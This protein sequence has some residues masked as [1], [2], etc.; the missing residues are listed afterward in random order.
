MAYNIPVYVP[1]YSKNDIRWIYNGEEGNEDVT[2]RPV[3]DVVDLVETAIR[4]T[5]PVKSAV[6]ASTL[7]HIPFTTYD[8]NN[9]YGYKHSSSVSAN[10][11]NGSTTITLQTTAQAEE[12]MV[13]ATIT[14]AGIQ[15]NTSV[16]SIN[17][18]NRQI[19]VSKA[20]TLT[21]L[22]TITYS[23]I[24]SQLTIDSI[25]L[26][27][28]DRILIKNQENA[29]LNGIYIVQEAGNSSTQWIITRSEDAKMWN[30]IASSIILVEQG[31]NFKDTVFICSSNKNSGVV[32]TNDLI[33]QPISGSGSGQML[34]NAGV[35]VFS[36]NAQELIE[37]IVVPSNVNCSAVG[38]IIVRD[39]V[40]LTINDGSRI[41]II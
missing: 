23:Q 31:E 25:L 37:N 28:T 30:Q 3:N 6:K 12:F 39:G 18:T 21:G 7:E 1:R 40:K 20:S 9:I 36:Y 14:G 4:E 24:I 8:E 26:Y 2:N 13:G 32:G 29:A 22:Q 38:P 27:N 5:I 11:I 34:G 16:V 35:K 33:F 17:V 10:L 19:I 41:I 15:T